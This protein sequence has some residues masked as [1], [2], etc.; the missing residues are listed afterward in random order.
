VGCK[1]SFQTTRYDLPDPSCSYTTMPI[2][3]HFPWP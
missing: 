3:R 2:E 1:P